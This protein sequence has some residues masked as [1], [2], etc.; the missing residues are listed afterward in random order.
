MRSGL[1]SGWEGVKGWFGD[2]WSDIKGAF[3]ATKEAMEQVSG[4]MRSGLKSGWE[5]ISGF[6]GDIWT[7][8]KDAFSGALSALSSVS[9]SMRSGLKAGWEGISGFFGDI[10]TSIK[11]PFAGV[12]TWF[13]DAFSGA[14]DAVTSPFSGI[15]TWFQTNV[16]NPVKSVFQPLLKFFGLGDS[17]SDTLKKDLDNAKYWRDFYDQKIRIGYDDSYI[18]SQYVYW[19]KEAAR[20][21]SEVDKAGSAGVGGIFAAIKK[22]FEDAWNWIRD[23]FGNI[24]SWLSKNIIDGLVNGLSNVGSTLTN[25]IGGF[26]GD[27]ID[28]IKNFFGIHSPST[29]MRDEVGLMIGAGMAEGIRDSYDTVRRASDELS[30]AVSVGGTAGIAGGGAAGGKSVTYVQNITSPTALSTADIYRQT[31]TLVGRSAVL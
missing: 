25:A 6:F 3:S 24:G 18:Y 9:A 27:V 17:S 4:L 30:G 13:R 16:L 12:G 11:S 22:P 2:R 21:A 5:G 23:T 20:L 10:W 28:G 7:G 29:L 15:G 31:R 14:F 1:Q 19:E 26:C 8:I